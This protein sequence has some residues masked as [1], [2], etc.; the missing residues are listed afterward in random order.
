MILPI[1]TYSDEVLR[2]KAKPLKE[3]DAQLEE[4]I[5][6]MLESMRNAEG[7]GLAAPQVGVSLRL[8]V[9]DLSLAEGYEAA[10]PMVVIN[11]H[12][13]S[14][15]SFNSM[16]EGCLS[17]PD[18]RGDV[19]R[20]SAIQLKYRDRNFEECIG[21]FDRLAARVIQHEIDHLDGT[22]FVDRMQRRD[23]RK[24]QKELDA[25]SRGEINTNYPV[26]FH[27]DSVVK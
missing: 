22:L 23:R 9:V 25:L 1:N 19:V 11:P 8:I 12:I 5:S 16:E 6:N 17:I 21:E 2:R 24:I 18:V 20:P 13:L 10:S 27:E 3:S 15:K 14:V 26:A 4:L 7:I